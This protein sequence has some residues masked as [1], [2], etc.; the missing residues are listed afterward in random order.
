MPTLLSDRAFMCW[1]Q[2][3]RSHQLMKLFMS[4]SLNHYKDKKRNRFYHNNDPFSAAFGNV[5]KALTV[6]T[7]RIKR[8]R[9]DEI[10]TE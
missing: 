4:L 3:A 5:V 6:W 8:N 9:A 7:N 2:G 10:C 1:K